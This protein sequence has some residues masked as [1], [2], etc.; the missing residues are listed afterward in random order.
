MSSGNHLQEDTSNDDYWYGQL[1]PP[2]ALPLRLQTKV[3]TVTLAIT[4]CLLN[5]LETA[6][7]EA[8]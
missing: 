2:T 7:I 6:T 1:S 5:S 8:V 3:Y 4:A